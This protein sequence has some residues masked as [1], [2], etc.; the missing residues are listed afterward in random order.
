MAPTNAAAFEKAGIPFCLTTS[1][2]RDVK[3]FLANLRT[4]LNYGLTETAALNALTKTPAT[5]LG[6]YDEVGSLEAGKW[7]NFLITSGPIFNE[8]TTIFQNWIQGIKIH[9]KR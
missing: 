8:K 5:V 2:L 7:A 3:S 9:C 4:A 1:D 6:I